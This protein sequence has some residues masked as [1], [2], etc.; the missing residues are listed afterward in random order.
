MHSA[1][2]AAGFSPPPVSKRD[3]TIPYLPAD[4]VPEEN[5]FLVG[6]IDGRLPNELRGTLYRN[7]P[8]TYES[9]GTMLQHPFDGDGMMSMFVFADGR[10]RVRNRYVRTPN[11]LA[12]RTRRGLRFRALGSNR[13][14]GMLA[15]A[16]RL[17]ANVA[18]TSVMFQA[19]DLL[20]LWEGG[21]PFAL[22]PNTLDTLGIH[23]FDGKLRWMGT[24]SAHPKTDPSTGEVYNFGVEAFPVPHLRCYRIDRRGRMHRLR[25]V[26][27]PN[28]SIVHDFALTQ[29][30]LVFVVDPLKLDLLRIAAGMG[31]VASNVRFHSENATLF[32]L[33]P[34][35]GSKPTIVEHAAVMHF[36]INNAFEDGND[37]VVDFIEYS[38]ARI[39][40]LTSHLRTEAQPN[41]RSSLHRYRISPGRRVIRQELC[42]WAG[43]FP[44]HDRRRTTFQ[45]RYSYY[46]G[47]PQESA[48][49][50]FG[51]A[52]IKADHKTEQFTVQDRGPG[53][54]L[55]E[56]VFV[57]RAG[58][59]AE[60]DGWLLTVAYD[61]A[62]Q[63]SNLLVLDARDMDAEPVAIVRIPRYIPPGYHGI[64]TDRIARPPALPCESR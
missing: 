15:N 14:G 5:D 25:S 9:G 19:G 26:R 42:P 22:D 48:S 36:H 47:V 56:P 41:F 20:A 12:G 32:I 43:E 49:N 13:P 64:F 33:V 40:F 61:A 8:G 31:S 4:G 3:L 54:L 63:R 2:D 17:P 21:K 24:F 37:T 59:A 29:K 28:F 7:G 10:V 46:T 62:A 16:L 18:N 39:L 45:H 30:H 23:D 38:D 60:D 11:Y 27:L 34:R 35:D 51:R 50:A 52:I 55:S 1:N 57:P 44:N 6:D 53:E 58:D